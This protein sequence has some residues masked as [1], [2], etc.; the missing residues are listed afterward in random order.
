VLDTPD[1]KTQPELGGSNANQLSGADFE[2]PRPNNYTQPRVQSQEQWESVT[3]DIRQKGENYFVLAETN[4]DGATRLAEFCRSQGLETYVISRKNVTSRYLVYACPG[5][6]DGE[7]STPVVKN[8]EQSIYRIGDLWKNNK[9]GDT[10]LH[11][12]YPKLYDGKPW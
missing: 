6:N 1:R 8:L 11:D 4:K 12:A 2:E 9:R 5:F 10:N 3:S 7:R